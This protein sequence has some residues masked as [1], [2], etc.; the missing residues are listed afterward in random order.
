[1]WL[2]VWSRAE[3]TNRFPRKEIRFRLHLRR[4]HKADDWSLV[5]YH[6]V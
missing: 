3:K 1:M 5:A 6:L 4:P 2:F